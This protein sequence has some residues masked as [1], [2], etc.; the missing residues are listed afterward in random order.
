MH[1]KGQKIWIW[2][3]FERQTGKIVGIAFGNRSA[4]IG[5]ALWVSLPADYR[6][7]ASIYTDA[8]KSYPCFLPKNRHRPRKKGS[9]ETNRIERFNN[10]LRQR[11]ANLVRKTLSFS[12]HVL[13]HEIRIRMFI[14]HHN[15]TVSV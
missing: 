7:R 13:L 9:G 12:K 15:Q 2:L 4:E 10:T 11:C 1:H 8:Y 6:K 14:E 3:A 5:R